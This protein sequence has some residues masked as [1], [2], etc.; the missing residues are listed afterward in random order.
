MTPLIQENHHGASSMTNSLSSS[1]LENE[2]L[3][4]TQLHYDPVKCE[5]KL[6]RQI[7]CESPIS[8]D[9]F[10][11]DYFEDEKSQDDALYCPLSPSKWI[12]PLDNKKVLV[13]P[14]KLASEPAS[15]YCQ[16]EDVAS[17]RRRCK[18]DGYEVVKLDKPFFIMDFLEHVDPEDL[19]LARRL[20]NAD[21]V[22]SSSL[23]PKDSVLNCTTRQTTVKK[24]LFPSSSPVTISE[25]EVTV[26]TVASST[27][28]SEGRSV[29]PLAA[30]SIFFQ[31]SVAIGN[32]FNAR[33]IKCA[34]CGNWKKALA[35]WEDALEVR[36]QVL[37]ESLDVAN[38]CNN[39]GIALGK[40]N[41]YEEAIT[42]L[43]RSLDIRIKQYGW[44]HE[45]VAATFHNMGNV[46][47]QS[48]DLRAAI[49]C[50]RQSEA[51]LE[52]LHGRDHPEVARSLVAM[53][54][55]YNQG[56]AVVDAR[57]AYF[58]ALTIF[59]RVGFHV[60]HPE[61]QSIIDDLKQLDQLLLHQG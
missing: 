7:Q 21:K 61:V 5:R 9:Q 28:E 20:L 50:F 44:D 19:E 26:Q 33:G 38:T 39:I 42:S 32:K 40:L 8:S 47:Q 22:Q 60:D 27:K 24:I 1:S 48:F 34:T 18:E 51:I 30:T 52:Q 55:T 46:Y 45:V 43:Q 58:D 54:H 14:N 25:S 31:R 29:Q 57:Q 15:S 53:G 36:S 49:E 3:A 17:Q 2:P 37:G 10:P 6:D 13:Y 16:S 12:E 35:Y 41:R 59:E 56:E 4:T 11:H 23:R